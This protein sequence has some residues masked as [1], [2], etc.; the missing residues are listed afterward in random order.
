MLIKKDNYFGLWYMRADLNLVNLHNP[1]QHFQQYVWG[2]C[3]QQDI[4]MW[5]SIHFWIMVLNGI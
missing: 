5:V 4:G 3:V 2:N 1:E